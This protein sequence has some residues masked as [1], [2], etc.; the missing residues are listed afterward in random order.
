MSYYYNLGEKKSKKDRRPTILLFVSIFLFI[1]LVVLIDEG[2]S[3]RFGN[4]FTI[5]KIS[6][7]LNESI[8]GKPQRN[9]SY[10]PK[11]TADSE[12]T[13]LILSVLNDEKLDQKVINHITSITVIDDLQQLQVKCEWMGSGGCIREGYTEI[14]LPPSGLFKDSCS[15]FEHVLYHEIGHVDYIVNHAGELLNNNEIEYFAENFADKHK[16][17]TCPKSLRLFH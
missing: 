16:A 2:L 9:L 3:G 8:H 13:K 6:E 10:V 12:N 14:Y 15:S 11:I 1:I 7:Q 17:D 4:D 5:E